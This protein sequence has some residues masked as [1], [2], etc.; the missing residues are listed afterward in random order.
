MIPEEIKNRII[1]ANDIYDIVKESG[2]Q[3][4]KKGAR[5]TG[6]CPFH[7]ERTPSFSVDPSKNMWYCFGC[8]EGGDVVSYVMKKEVVDFPEALRILAKRVNIKIE[9]TDPTPEQIEERTK[10]EQLEVAMEWATKYYIE[11][12]QGDDRRAC[13]AREYAENRWGA[14]TVE[15]ERLGF[16]PGGTSL[17]D[18]ATKKG[19][20]TDILEQAGLVKNYDGRLRD[21]FF[22]RLVIPIIN[23]RGKVI[24]FTGRALGES[25]AKYVNSAETPIYKKS[26]G[27]FGIKNAM[28]QIAK[29]GVAY[30]VEG[31]PDVLKMQSV[32][33]AN[34]V[35][36][37]GTALTV[38]QL[39]TIRRTAKTLIFIPD[40]DPPK[41]GE[42][43]GAGTKAVMKSGRLAIEQGFGVMV[44]EIPPG[45]DENGDPKK[46]DPDS[47]FTH[48]SKLKELTPESYIEWYAK[49][50]MESGSITQQRELVN[51]CYPILAAIDDVVERKNALRTL[52]KITGHLMSFL[53]QGFN[54]F[55]NKLKGEEAAEQTG[56]T[57]KRRMFEKYGFFEDDHEYHSY[58]NGEVVEWSNFTLEP[59][60]HIKDLVNAKRVFRI[61]NSSGSEDIIEF[62]QEELGSSSRFRSRI[63]SLGYYI[64]EGDD[65][66]LIKMTKYLYQKTETAREITQMGWNRAG[67]YVFGNGAFYKNEWYDTDEMGML[68]LGEAGN[69]YVPSASIIYRNERSFFTF[70]RSF[71]HVKT[72]RIT[73]KSFTSKMFDV[74]GTPGKIGFAFMIASLFK[75]III[76]KTR[77]FPMLNLFG[78]KGSGKSQ[79]SQCLMA[80]YGTK[81]EA[82]N[83]SNSTDAACAEAIAQVSDGLVTLEEY[84]NTIDLRRREMIKDLYDGNGRQRMNIDRDKKREVSAVD[85]GIIIVGQEAP[86]VDIALFSRMVHVPLSK[87]QFSKEEKVKY[88]E[89]KDICTLGLTHLTLELLEHRVFFERNFRRFY[90]ICDD[91]ISE[92][93]GDEQ[94]ET[95]ILN[96][97]ITILAAYR[98]LSDRLE[99]PIDPAELRKTCV[100]GIRYQ[101]KACKRND[102]RAVFWATVDFL[103]QDGQI[104]NEGDYRIIYETTVM[105]KELSAP[106]EFTDSKPVLYLST[107]RV[108]A[109]YR[110]QCKTLGEPSQSQQSLEHYLKTSDSFLGT[111]RSMR[112]K[113]ISNDREMTTIVSTDTGGFRNVATSRVEMALA[114]DYEKLVDQYGLSLL[115][116]TTPLTD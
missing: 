22:D 82:T 4:T 84:K 75:D 72:G 103:H 83:L 115:V 39:Y 101:N 48:S 14:H 107:K 53:T 89:L 87:T 37:L 44:A 60:I 65:V 5:F 29:E 94:V 34:V 114:F 74:Y 76:E 45:K 80:F 79:L 50:V 90:E 73:L 91:E 105:T 18:W 66:N 57:S 97:W 43:F 100:E 96:N 71:I 92:A 23:T 106:I 85:S 99:N 98:T 9:E 116:D 77:N 111:K 16:A 54:E 95:R 32:G 24:A 112:F 109:L 70:E 69:W 36:P 51:D 67:F 30:I 15:T 42:R 62:K 6:C 28:S 11:C 33:I 108:F 102:E 40:Q 81:R 7:S 21:V 8:H 27:L 1:E 38:S 41:P 110:K 20:A 2:V 10:K 59:L 13:F 12:L 52:S 64:W 25:K 19:L 31:G 17:L 56:D 49:K 78:N 88:E 55:R 26:E 63:A 58:K 104:H 86:D 93:L 46:E 113:N 68:R 35:A 61:K 47:F 3:L